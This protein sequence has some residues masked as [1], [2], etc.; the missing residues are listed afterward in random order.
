MHL[1]MDHRAFVIGT[2]GSPLALAQTDETRRRLGALRPVLA[3]SGRLSTRVITTSG[4]RV[5]DRTLAEIGGKGLFTK[6]IDEAMLDGTIDIAVHSIKDLPTFLPDGI[7][8]ACALPRADPRDAFIGRDVAGLAALPPGAVFGTASLRRQ[9][10]VLARR[11]D[12]QIVPL[13]G[14]VQ[15]R[16][17]KVEAG[18]V[19]ATMLAMAGL[20]RLG[21]PDAASS[22]IE[23]DELLPAVGQGAIGITCRS[24]DAGAWEVLSDL[25]DA[26]TMTRIA[27]ERAMLEVLD[28]SCRTPIA[29]LAEMRDDGRLRLRGLIA[30]P[31]G[32]Q[33][34]TGERTGLPAD[35]KALGRDL[36]TELRGRAGPGFFAGVA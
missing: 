18:T 20:M 19:D 32:S 8:F 9:A 23:T 17:G 35:A 24:D 16:L 14:N 4:D 25:N 7:A 10:Q 15:T 5:L 26:Q 27:A 34:L 11:P 2:R 31:D 13:R 22:P 28:G 12:L 1:S 33:I 3:D 29:G 21:M 30:R 6:E 36:G